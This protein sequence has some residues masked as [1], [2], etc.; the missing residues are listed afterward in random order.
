[1]ALAAPCGALLVALAAAVMLLHAGTA[2]AHNAEASGAYTCDGGWTYTA[3]YVNGGTS[4]S[5]NN[6]LAI[7]DVDVGGTVVKEYHYFDTLTS[8]PAPPAGFIVVDHEVMDTFRL[9]ELSGTTGPITATGSIKLYVDG[10]RRDPSSDPVYDRYQPG[11]SLETM[12]GLA[13]ASGCATPTATVTPAPTSTS[14][15]TPTATPTNTDPVARFTFQPGTPLESDFVQFIDQSYDADAGDS[16][17][18]WA[19]TFEGAGVAAKTS[20]LQNPIFSFPDDGTFNVSLTVT[21]S[22]GG[23]STVSSGSEAGDGTLIPAA[24]IGNAGMLVSALNLEV[25]AGEPAHLTARFLDPGWLDTH[26]ASWTV[27]GTPVPATVLEEHEPALASGLITGTFATSGEGVLSGTLEVSDDGGETATATFQI[28]VLGDGF[29]RREAND[30]VAT[31]PQL[32]GGGVYLSDLGSPGDVDLY[33]AV[34]PSGGSLPA[35]SELLVTLSNVPADYDVVVLAHSPS[36]VASAP[37]LS[38]P[39]LS[40]PFLSSPFLS[41]PFLSS[42]FL[43]SPFLSSPFLSSPFLSSP[44]LSSPFLS[45]PFLSS[46]FLSSPFLSSALTFDQFPLSQIG[47]A[48]PSGSDIYGSDVS[49]V[50]LGLGALADEDLQVVGHSANRGIADERVLVRTDAPGTRLYVAVVGNNGAYASAPYS[51][52]IET[53]RPLDLQAFLGSN[54]SGSIVVGGSAATSSLAVLYD[55]P[56]T[57]L[58]LIVTQRERMMALYGLDDAGWN[59]LMTDLIALAN[60]AS[61]AADIVSVPS[62]IFDAW[63]TDPCSIDAANAVTEDVH[64]AIMPLLQGDANKRYLVFAGNDDVIPHRRVPDETVIGNESLYAVD[65]FLM[66]GSPLSSSINLGMSLTD[67]YYADADPQPWQGRELYVPDWDLGRLVETPDEIRAAAQ[68]F[69]ASDGQLTLDSALVTG[70]DFFSDGSTQTADA[71]SA[72]TPDRLIREDWTRD[73]LKCAFLATPA[74][75]GCSAHDVNAANA[76]FTHYAALS[77]NGFTTKNFSDFLTSADVAGAGGGTPALAGTLTFT[78]GCHGGLSVP[79]RQGI[80]PEAGLTVDPRLDFAQ[81]MARQRAVYVANTGFGVGESDGVAGNEELMIIF[82]QELAKGGAAGDALAAAKRE[83]LLRQSALSVYVEK[84]SI[85]TTLWGLPQYQANVPAGFTATASGPDA[86]ISAVPASA[87]ITIEDG[88]ATIVATPVLTTETTSD[89]SYLKAD[90]GY[91]ATVARAIQPRVLV[92]LPEDA[93][94]GPV[95]GIVVRGGTYEDTEPFDPVIARPQQEWDVVTQEPQVCLEAYWPSVFALVNSLSSPGGLLQ[96]AVVVPAQF[97]CTSGAA[98]TV[99]G[100]ERVYES[101]QLAVRRSTS[102]DYEPPAL[103]DEGLRIVDNGSGSLRVTVDATD[104]SGIAEI[105]AYVLQDGSLVVAESGPLEGEGPFSLDIPVS[106]SE[107]ERLVVQIVDGAGNV[108]TLTGK[109]VNLR[110]VRVDAGADQDVNPPG[111]ATLSGAVLNFDDLIG[112]AVDISYVW[113]FG[114][115]SFAG[116]L[117]AVDG[118][119][120]P[121]VTIDGD[122]TAHFTVQ[123]QYAPESVGNV[124]A[125]LTV[126]DGLGGVGIDTSGVA[127]CTDAEVCDT[128]QDGVVNATDNCVTTPNPGQENND[129]E[130]RSNGPN[131]I[132]D[133]VTSPFHD[134]AGDIC[135]DDDDNDGLSDSDEDSGALCSGTVTARLLIDTDGDHLADGWECTHG[136]DPTDEGSR[137]LGEISLIDADGDD[138]FD[139]IEQRGYNTSTATRDTDGDGCSDYGEIGSV[140]GD[141]ALNSGDGLIMLRRIADVLA[142]DTVQDYVLDVN[143]DGFVNST[144]VLWVMRG[145]YIVAPAPC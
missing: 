142:P 119:G 85:T 32:R 63:D 86:G 130:V 34:L 69:V 50:E 120:Q 131:I 44:F 6:R 59:D 52:G 30:S 124:T 3:D 8:H 20:D 41:S 83:F 106:A 91:Q 21:D 47:F 129:Q 33:E 14:T 1:M 17:V 102:S 79:D 35:G 114:D 57:D 53:S 100:L 136:S 94:N 116:G 89:G 126:M 23:T 73:E 58:S 90:G 62:T 42:P 40:S 31:A 7:V 144:D 16:I 101:L 78:I 27:E 72:L 15:T 98:A 134:D 96:K 25:K 67:D 55:H 93:T 135:D 81:A 145:A 28:T 71:L 133:D 22:F 137:Y 39:F 65:S 128:D 64:D 36:S 140:N 110:I 95:H 139:Q 115:G 143:K 113:D 45:S 74:G 82:A 88:A 121:I 111:P 11:F 107:G 68:A 49:L 76:H 80:P 125:T 127:L 26:T 109:G 122:G 61:V 2:E 4:G 87:N 84:A 29:D 118:V 141:R 99:T 123:H 77:A 132:G 66:P 18:S 54:C 9:L 75:P 60:H 97:R 10:R 108:S 19:W 56:G 138:V 92:D 48:A 12:P 5:G 13:D 37:F 117:L 46:P 51:L 24:A 38:S 43:S 112:E 105:I 103:G 70:Y 104:D